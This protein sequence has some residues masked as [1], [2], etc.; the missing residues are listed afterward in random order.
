MNWTLHIESSGFFYIVCIST[1]II[2]LRS[3]RPYQFSLNLY[4][5]SYSL[6]AVSAGECNDAK[7]YLPEDG[8]VNALLFHVGQLIPS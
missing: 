5:I 3:Q 8:Q 6:F 4:S 2:T 7:G 1:N